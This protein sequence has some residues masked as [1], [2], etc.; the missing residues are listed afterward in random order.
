MSGAVMKYVA[1]GD[2]IAAINPPARALTT[3]ATLSV[4]WTRPRPFEQV[5]VVGLLQHRVVHERLERARPHREEHAEG[6]GADEIRRHVVADAADH[7]A[8]RERDVADDED[9]AT[10]PPVGQDAGRNLDE[11]NDAGVDRRKHPNTRGGEADLVHEQFLDRHP[12]G[13]PAEERG[14]TQRQQAPG[15]A[16]TSRVV[17]AGGGGS[18]STIWVALIPEPS[19]DGRSCYTVSRPAP[20]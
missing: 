6:Q 13:E 17:G 11:R 8:G 20:R 12:N 15:K 10:A 5:A 2:V 19:R 3:R 14:D 18:V 1:R 4:S 9:P 7:R 16:K